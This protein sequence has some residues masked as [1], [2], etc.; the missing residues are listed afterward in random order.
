MDFDWRL[1]LGLFSWLFKKRGAVSET[2]S[3]PVPNSLRE[4]VANQPSGHQK[5]SRAR[6]R[7]RE[8]SYPMEV[9]GESNY[10]RALQ[11]ICGK[12]NRHG[13]EVLVDAQLLREPQNPHDSNAVAVTINGDK[14]GYISRDQA[15]RVSMQMVEDGI[16]RVTCAAKIVGGWRTNQHDEGSF[17]VRLAVPNRDWIDF[18]LGKQNL[19][20]VAKQ[21]LQDRLG[22]KTRPIAADSGP[23]KGQFLVVWG[24]PDHGDEAVELAAKGA[25]VMKS[26]GKSTTM[27]V[28]VNDDLTPGMM[29]SSVYKK[30]QE[31]KS[32]GANIELVTLK[33]LRARLKR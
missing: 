11:R 13:H 21:A 12:H 24:A 31:R 33:N 25:Q 4:A 29:N 3:D 23:L 2:A 28:Q 1:V 9:V 32:V 17:G 20:S 26:V 18:G 15:V 19:D 27:V 14:V 7:W 30:F 10:Q 8:G 5:P 22:A 16:D 6:V